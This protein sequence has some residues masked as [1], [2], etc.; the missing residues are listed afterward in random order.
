MALKISLYTLL[1]SKVSLEE[2]VKLDPSDARAQ[3]LLGEVSLRSGNPGVA[4]KSALEV[5]QRNPAN[6]L[7]AILL[8]DSFLARNESARRIAA[9]AFAGLRCNTSSADFSATPGFPERKETSPRS[10]W[11]RASDGSSF[12]ASSSETLLASKV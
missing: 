12:T 11:A 4:E 6:A 3:L 1:A 8:A 5:L 9:S 7:A 10:N 2:A